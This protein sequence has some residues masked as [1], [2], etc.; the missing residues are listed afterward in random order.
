MFMAGLFIIAKTWKQPRRPSHGEWKT[1]APPD[2]RTLFSSKEQGASTHHKKTQR[3]LQ[4]VL[5]SEG[6]QSEKAGCCMIPTM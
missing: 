1:V 5:L 2:S 4:C 3:K 6:N